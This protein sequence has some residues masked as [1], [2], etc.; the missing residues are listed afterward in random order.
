MRLN[1][2]DDSEFIMQNA[3]N[4][5]GKEGVTVQTTYEVMTEDI[6]VEKMADA[7]SVAG[8]L[9]T[10]DV[11]DSAPFGDGWKHSGGCIANRSVVHS[12]AARLGPF[13]I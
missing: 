7:T 12:P 1:E 13:S 6:D 8:S 11:N 4:G 3:S 10:T 5:Q 2:Y 9:A